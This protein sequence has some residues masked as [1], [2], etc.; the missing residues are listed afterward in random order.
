MSPSG[1]GTDSL[2]ILRDAV[3]ERYSVE[4]QLG[5]GGMAIVFLAQDRKHGRPVALKVLRP[6]L[7]AALGR[8]RF[9]REIQLAA[10]LTH[11]H[12]LPLYDSG[13]AAGLLYYVMPYVEG[14]SLRDRLNRTK[15]LA[16][17]DALQV[18]REVADALSHA[19]GRN[20]VHRDIKPENILL[21]AGHAV[22][23]DFGIARAISAAGGQ[24]LTQPGLFVG[25]PHYTSPEQVGSDRPVD[26]RS[27]LYS[28]GCVL[29]EMLTGHP[30]L[31][32]L[33]DLAL[34]AQRLTS[35]APSLR[36][37]MVSVPDAID[38]LVARL[39]AREP[40]DR[41]QTAGEVAQRLSTIASETGRASH[42]TP[43][44]ARFPSRLRLRML[45]A[46]SIEGNAGRLSGAAAQPKS[47]ALLAL[48]AAAGDRG[49]SRDK[50][51]AF[52]WPE[53]EAE[54]A[55]H[56]L[57]Q[58]LHALRQELKVE[59]VFLG[60]GDLRL[61]PGVV[62]T[63][64]GEFRDAVD[65]GALERAVSLYGGPFLD[66]FYLSDAVEFERWVDGERAQYAT[67]FSTALESLATAA[68]QQGDRRRAAEWWRRLAETDPLNSRIAVCF[69][70]A[71]S[72]AGDRA[73]A[74][75]F[76]QVH[77]Q[78]L[79]EELDA[80]PDPAVVAAIQRIRTA[81]AELPPTVLPQREAAPVAAIAVLPFVNLSSDREDEYFSDGMTDELINAL[82][83]V[84]ELRVASR[85]SSFVFKGKNADVHEI[86]DRL[87]V[88]AIVE[89]SVRK[90]ADKVRIT[91]QLVTVADGYHLWSETY[92]RTLADVF[93]VQEELARAIV[94]ALSLKL[95]GAPVVAP[96]TSV[97]E[98]YTLYL[99]GRYCANRR[100]SESLRAGCEYFQQAIERDP[101]YALAYAGLAECYALRGF[102]EFSPDLP[103]REAMPPAKA[104]ARKALELDPT[105]ADAHC[106][107]GA[108]AL[109]FDWD[110]AA[111][112]REL[113]QA[114]S[115]NPRALLA[116]IW[117]A[118]FLYATGDV[119]ESLR[120]IERAE[121]LDPG[122]LIVQ[123]TGARCHY[124]AGH[125][126]AAIER[127]RATLDL[128]PTYLLAHV[129]LGRV[130]AAKGLFR[131]AVQVLEQ[132]MSRVGRLP[133]ILMQCGAAYGRLG[134]RREAL[135]ILAELRQ[136][137]ARRYVPAVYEAILLSGLGDL[138]EAFQ[139]LNDACE[140]RSGYV[141]FL[142]DPLWDRIRS[143][144]RYSALLKKM[145]LES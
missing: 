27:D 118:I 143:D 13:E 6:E 133:I 125:Y 24:N 123:I 79:R 96:A 88:G 8:D 120:V 91:A 22:V 110:R 102:E 87:K 14:E 116:L 33:S 15:L 134:A 97:L 107:L 29:F 2:S 94:S 61:N 39:L 130:Y 115:L 4:R 41:Y 10:C 98:A 30:P 144:P 23:S 40:A 57:S 139:R 25:T 112:E 90:A 66:G 46:P 64:V 53:T 75:Q 82:T 65:R 145:G 3:A 49:I 45:G 86:G 70:E 50:V 140:Q 121:A 68:S 73:A 16:L 52:L 111:A 92:E 99:R 117:Y 37:K 54:K 43:R 105:I 18:A 20:V 42:S 101:S 5:Q 9:L 11:P 7:A 32:H 113:Q 122:S 137:A 67:L 89:G 141:M 83:Q 76:A 51:L 47:L 84:K 119:D 35:P 38:E 72:A 142:L 19:H 74:L 48:L 85:T 136:N 58:L 44:G 124:Y 95:V 109:L 60:R 36:S 108:I 103:P 78:R 138:D 131:E 129:W 77:E 127:L 26:G 132:A 1:S 100:T 34:I 31:A 56:R 106:W 135:E 80:A 71:L 12:I 55:T 81:P 62:F 114:L 93:A 126:D 28:L 104:A 59:E 128:E 63:D 21:E 69:L 17:K